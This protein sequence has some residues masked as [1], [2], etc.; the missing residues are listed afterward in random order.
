MWTDT[1][2][3]DI[4]PIPAPSWEAAA[5]AYGV[6]AFQVKILKISMKIYYSS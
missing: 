4:A 1:R 2:N 5:L 3:L 6:I